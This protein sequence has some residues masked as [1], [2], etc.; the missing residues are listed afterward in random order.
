MYLNS[1][2]YSSAFPLQQWLHEHTTVSCYAYVACFVFGSDLAIFILVWNA[3]F[4]NEVL[5]L[6]EFIGSVAR[7]IV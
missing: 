2:Q 5:H 7:N 3:Q 6:I 1:T 4:S